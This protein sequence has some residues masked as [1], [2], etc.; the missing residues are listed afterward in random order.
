M[1]VVFME[2]STCEV[3]FVSR[4]RVRIRQTDDITTLIKTIERAIWTISNVS[5]QDSKQYAL[6]GLLQGSAS[7]AI[8]SPKKA[9][10]R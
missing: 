1:G 8:S 10:Q 6:T 7:S 5:P 9:T 3:E 4:T 2:F